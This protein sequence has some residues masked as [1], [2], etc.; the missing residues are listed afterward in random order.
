MSTILI[1][2]GYESDAKQNWFPWIKT[3]LEKNKH[4]V[5]VPSFPHSDAPTLEEWREHM[6][7][8]KESIDAD[9]VVVGHSRGGAF[10][11]RLL[12][13]IHHPIRATFLIA[14]V[15][16]TPDNEFAPLMTTFTE[17]PYDW[18]TIK[19]NA[20]T[21]HIIHGD[22]DEYLPLPYAEELQKNL[23]CGMT[24]VAGGRHLNAPA[25]YTEFPALR[26]SVLALL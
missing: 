17:K 12:E 3:E 21:I 7:K 4:R 25:G 23:G 2:H 20:G 22:N 14:S 18:K 11:L 1:I 9:P 16:E 26:D 13:E 24:V 5:I 19:K 15:W 10:A 8:Y 6:K